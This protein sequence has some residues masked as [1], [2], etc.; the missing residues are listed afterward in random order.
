MLIGTVDISRVELIG[1]K[2]EEKVKNTLRDNAD[3]TCLGEEGNSWWEHVLTWPAVYA[4]V[5]SNP[6]R[7]ET[8]Y[9]I[10][11]LRGCQIWRRLSKMKVVTK[12]DH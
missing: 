9:P 6:Y 3:K 2:G 8:P 12:T 5:L 10:Q 4:W 11:P 7:F 1:Y